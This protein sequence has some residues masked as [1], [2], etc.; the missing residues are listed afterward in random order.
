MK[1]HYF[2][3]LNLKWPGTPTPSKESRPKKAPQFNPHS[4]TLLLEPQAI[5]PLLCQHW[6]PWG[7][8]LR[9]LAQIYHQVQL[10]HFLQIQ[11]YFTSS[12][13]H[14]FFI[15]KRITLNI[16]K[17][18]YQCLSL[19][20]SSI[21]RTQY[22]Y[23]VWSKGIPKQWTLRCDIIETTKDTCEEPRYAPPSRT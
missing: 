12:S 21:K 15:S 6:I 14:A 9:I 16:S 4:W 11:V 18:Y 22:I 13:Y 20:F 2:P 23:I 17:W 7:I 19:I 5:H 3:K 1:I 8:Q 10:W